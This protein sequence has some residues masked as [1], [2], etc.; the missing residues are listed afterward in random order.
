MTFDWQ[1]YD[2]EDVG[3]SKETMREE[4][5]RSA[6]MSAPRGPDI[7]FRNMAGQHLVQLVPYAFPMGEG[8]GFDLQTNFFTHDAKIVPEG[9]RY[10]RKVPFIDP[11]AP[12]LVKKMK[13]ELAGWKLI[14]PQATH[15]QDCPICQLKWDLAEEL[16]PIYGDKVWKRPIFIE[17]GLYNNF[18]G[19][20]FFRVIQSAGEFLETDEGKAWME[21]QFAS[22]QGAGHE[23]KFQQQIVET[24]K[25]H[26]ARKAE[27]AVAEEQGVEVEERPL[28]AALYEELYGEMMEHAQDPTYHKPDNPL[29]AVVFRITTTINRANGFRK[30]TINPMHRQP[31][32]MTADGSPDKEAIYSFLSKTT[33][34]REYRKPW[35]HEIA[36]AVEERCRQIRELAKAERTEA[37]QVRGTTSDGTSYERQSVTDDLDDDDKGP[38]LKDSDVPF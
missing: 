4:M 12:E 11:N 28:I 38:A 15:G 10:S 13:R 22:L 23:K 34:L 6:G 35:S 8:T 1:N 24:Q 16:K 14:C 29:S 20:F 27:L 33:N 9:K 37:T 7:F 5:Q 19:L 30:T 32:F 21:R 3:A 26:A 31:L 25:A 2:L 18:S 17:N 36:D